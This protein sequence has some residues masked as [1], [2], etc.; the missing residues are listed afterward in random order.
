MPLLTL[1]SRWANPA[2]LKSTLES[3]F[4]TL[5]GSKEAAAAKQAEE[6]AKAKEAKAAGGAGA[7]AA[8]SSK[9]KKANA[10]AEA[11]SSSTKSGSTSTATPEVAHGPGPIIPTNIFQEGFLS[12]FH[13]PG[14]NPQIDP[15]LTK[16]HLEWT[17]GKVFTRFPPEPNGYLHIGK[18]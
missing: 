3:H 11:S 12:E 2:D 6:K 1:V 9:G 7:G 8:G 16:E 15:K 4:T 5:F 14:E 10:G 13:K 17:K 18:C